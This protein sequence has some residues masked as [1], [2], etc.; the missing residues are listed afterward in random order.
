MK[1]NLIWLGLLGLLLSSCCVRRIMPFRN[2]HQEDATKVLVTLHSIP[3]P[4]FFGF[5]NL[6]LKNI[7]GL[8]NIELEKNNSDLFVTIVPD[9]IWNSSLELP[10]RDIWTKSSS[11]SITIFEGRTPN[12]KAIQEVMRQHRCDELLARVFYGFDVRFWLSKKT[13]FVS[14]SDL[15][16]GHQLTLFTS[17]KL[18]DIIYAIVFG[19]NKKPHFDLLNSD[20][21]ADK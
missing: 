9:S 3:A 10:I 13:L 1:R 11:A 14:L 21:F 5:E 7:V 8:I 19:K 15:G 2:A 17:G 16:N 18:D 20:P 4:D 6:S 12:W